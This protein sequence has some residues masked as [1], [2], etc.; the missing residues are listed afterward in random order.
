MTIGLDYT[1]KY[2]GCQMSL[3]SLR[4]VASKAILSPGMPRGQRVHSGRG[5]AGNTLLFDLD[6]PVGEIAWHP[7]IVVARGGKQCE[8]ENDGERQSD[9]DQIGLPGPKLHQGG[10]DAP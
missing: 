8:E 3:Q 10:P 7:R 4:A 1:G 5:M 2:H 6:L 9:E